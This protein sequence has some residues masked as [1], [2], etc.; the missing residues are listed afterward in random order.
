MNHHEP[1]IL[2]ICPSTHPVQLFW[3]LVLVL[4]L[5][6]FVGD[7]HHRAGAV[8]RVMGSRTT[9]GAGLAID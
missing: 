2:D 5:F 4:K 8:R 1:P 7:R 6:G 9:P 3:A